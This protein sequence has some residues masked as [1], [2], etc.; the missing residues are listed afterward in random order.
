MA[1]QSTM[2]VV[3]L[4][5]GHLHFQSAPALYAALLDVAQREKQKHGR[6]DAKEHQTTRTVALVSSLQCHCRPH[7]RIRFILPFR[8]D[9]LVLRFGNSGRAAMR[10]RQDRRFREV[11]VGWTMVQPFN[12]FFLALR[13]VEQKGKGSLQRIHD[14]SDRIGVLPD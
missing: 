1:Q 5:A 3:A 11:T 4:C 13:A 14:G 8:N 7:R 6:R 12:H 9:V 10:S 2:Y